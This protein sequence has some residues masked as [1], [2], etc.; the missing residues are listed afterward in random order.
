LVAHPAT[1]PRRIANEDTIGDGGATAYVQHPGA[2]VA[3]IGELIGFA[4]GDREALEHGTWAFTTY[5][6]HHMTMA[7]T[8]DGSSL[9]SVTT[10]Q[11][12]CLAVE[13]DGFEVSARPYDDLVVRIRCVDRCLDARESTGAATEIDVVDASYR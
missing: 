6:L 3:E 1:L 10:G 2:P 4:S 12:D 11:P 9:R 7:G 8:V 13:I 5:A